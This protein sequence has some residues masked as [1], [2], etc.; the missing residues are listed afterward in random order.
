VRAIIVAVKKMSA[1]PPSASVLQY[2]VRAGAMELIHRQG[3]E[4]KKSSEAGLTVLIRKANA[5][6]KFSIGHS[7]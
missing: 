7:V 2:A 3:L 4:T 1:V 6:V 5:V